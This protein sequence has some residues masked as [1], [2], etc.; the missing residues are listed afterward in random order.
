MRVQADRLLFDA[1]TSPYG[2]HS[3]LQSRDEAF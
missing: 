3:E 2:E 1:L